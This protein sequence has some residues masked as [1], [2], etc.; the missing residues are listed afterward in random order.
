MKFSESWLRSWFDPAITTQQ[1][2]EQFTLLGLEVNSVTKVSEQ[3]THVVAG[4]VLTVTPHPNAAR[5][6]VCTVTIGQADTLTIVCGAPNLR[7]GLCVAVAKPGAVLSADKTITETSFRGVVSQGMLC[8]AYELGL[9]DDHAGILELLD[10]VSLGRDLRDYFQLDDHSFDIHLTPN[11]GDCLSILGLAREIA[12]VHHNAV[13]LPEWPIISSVDETIV[14]ITIQDPKACP[15]YR[16]R[17]IHGINP[18]AQTPLWLSERLRRSHVRSIH[19]VV[20]VTNY[21]LLEL[22]QPLHAFDLN[23]LVS[24]IQV[25]SAKSGELI[26]LLNGKTVSLDPET[27]VI[28]DAQRPHAIAGVMGGF[29]SA[30][31]ADTDTIFLESAFFNPMCL[32]GRARQYGLDSEAAY[33]YERGVDPTLNHYALER[34]TQLILEIAGGTPSSI[35]CA[36]YPNHLPIKPRIFLRSAQIEAVLGLHFTDT[37]IITLLSNLG[38]QVEKEAQDYWVSVPSWRFDLNLEVDLIEELARLYGYQ[39]IPMRRAKRPAAKISN[40]RS[41]LQRLRQVLVDRG[42]YEAIT[43]SFV[44]PRAQQCIDPQCDPITVTNPIS[45]ELSVL[46]TSL[47]PGLLASVAYNH[48]RQHVRVRLFETGLRFI[49]NDHGVQQQSM[50]AGVISGDRYPEQWAEKTQAND[51][52]TLKADLEIL[53]QFMNVQAVFISALHPALHPGQTAAIQIQ[54]RVLGYCGALHP[55]L[56]DEFELQGPIYLFEIA[57]DPIVSSTVPTFLPYSKFPSMRRDLSFWIAAKISVQAVLEC[58]KASAG[59]YLHDVCLFDVYTSASDTTRRSLALGLIWQHPTRTLLDT[60][61]DAYFEQVLVDLRQHFQVQ[62]RD[63]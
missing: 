24:G 14:P 37:D 32:R 63:R 52:F 58:V 18:L 1:L 25:R 39:A 54:D 38:M 42:Y 41:L 45:S 23:Q 35:V 11:R 17:S 21:V 30:V 5:L 40:T 51:F 12:A 26:T 60:E 44:S 62:L 31:R 53:L 13:E 61:V 9:S 47:W 57:L 16:G 3:F 20:D 8:S 59:L 29:D 10:D 36:N 2:A 33:R 22:G 6:R 4:R 27:L 15:V 56:L 19:P 34:A 50:L 49:A 7:S 48:K 28:A 46:R 43:Y 55:K